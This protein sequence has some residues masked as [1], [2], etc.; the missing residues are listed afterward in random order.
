MFMF[1]FQPQTV[2]AIKEFVRTLI[3]GLIPAVVAA[4]GVIST[5]ISTETGV[6]NIPW[7]IVIAVLAVDVIAVTKTALMSAG[8]KW[9]HAHD[10][11]TVLD[12]T[13]LDSLTKK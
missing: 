3:L 1:K 2:E 12:L 10:V 7:G 8:D 11:E 4:L 13:S 6:F 5:G 9:L